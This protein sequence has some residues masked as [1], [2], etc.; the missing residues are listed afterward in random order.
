MQYSCLF[1]PKTFNL[2][3]RFE[4]H[5]NTHT[6][7]TPY[8]CSKCS[9]SFQSQV[10]L[11]NHVKLHHPT[12]RRSKAVPKSAGKINKKIFGF[13]SKVQPSRKPLASKTNQPT[14]ETTT[15]TVKTDYCVAVKSKQGHP[16]FKCTFCKNVY[17]EKSN[18][19]RHYKAHHVPGECTLCRIKFPSQ[20]LL[21]RHQLEKHPGVRKLYD[22]NICGNKY[23]ESG[24][25]HRHQKNSHKE[26]VR[27]KTKAVR[28]KVKQRGL[29]NSR[30]KCKQA[31][32]N[33]VE[34]VKLTATEFNNQ[35]IVADVSAQ[36]EIVTTDNDKQV[37]AVSDD[38]KQVVKEGG[39]GGYERH[40]NNF[41]NFMHDLYLE[42]EE[43][44]KYQNEHL[45][46]YFYHL[47]RY[48]SSS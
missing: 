48:S 42:M 17:T 33:A 21:N 1:C 34:M 8:H 14:T 13:K 46:S 31:S 44:Q 22:C 18:A 35:E 6:R 12:K 40:V 47:G 11:S 29:E 23:T 16:L 32:D 25:L 9:S 36:Q 4:R 15:E 45:A 7:E 30:G 28:K 10:K 39:T 2:S 38:D 27:P 19:Y 26:N 5:I 20:L 43:E 3:K 24:N 41:Y 37:I